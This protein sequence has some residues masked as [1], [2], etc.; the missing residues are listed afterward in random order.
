MGGRE[1]HFEGPGSFTITQAQSNIVEK[2]ERKKSH[3]PASVRYI[4]S[5]WAYC[6]QNR[7]KEK[8]VYRLKTQRESRVLDVKSGIGE[9]SPRGDS[10]GSG[11]KM[12]HGSVSQ[13]GWFTRGGK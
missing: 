10:R 1:R 9:I 5:L 2:R 3:V 8:R 11:G 6:K 13:N 7:N 12:T 4:L